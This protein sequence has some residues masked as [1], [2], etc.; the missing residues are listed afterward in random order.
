MVQNTSG[1][2][3][4]LGTRRLVLWT[5]ALCVVLLAAVLVWAFVV[6]PNGELGTTRATNSTPSATGALPNQ[7]AGESTAAKNNM[8][9][10]RT[11]PTAG[12]GQNAPGAAADIQQSAGPLRLSKQQ[13]AQVRSYLASK[14]SDRADNINFD[15]TLG[16]AVPQQVRLQ[17]LP[18]E[19]ASVMQGYQGDEYVVVGDQL[20]IVDPSARR[21][22]AIVPTAG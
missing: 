12:A 4:R 17:K 8:V 18:P 14:K 20:V 19:L 22:V 5:S 15:V 7:R 6:V 13:R 2:E 10:P 11:S 16:A 3:L 9:A 1:P 21:V